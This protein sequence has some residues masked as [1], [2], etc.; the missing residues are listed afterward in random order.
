MVRPA[1][2]ERHRRPTSCASGRRAPTMMSA[3][4]L[5]V[6]EMRRAKVR[7]GLLVFAVGLLV[8]LILTQQAL[9]DGLLTSFVGGIRNQ[10]A[11]VLVYSVDGQKALQG[12][13]V[14][15]PLE[16]AVRRHRGRGRGGPARP[17]HLHR[18]GRGR[19]QL[20]RG[21]SSAPTSPG[22]ARRRPSRRGRGRAAD[23]EAV[24][25]DVDFS[26]GDEVT[27]PAAGPGAEPVTTDRGGPGPTTSSSRSP[28]TLFTDF[29]TY[30]AAVRAANPDATAV[31]PN[32][33]AVEPAD[34]RRRRPAG[35]AHRRRL[36]RGR[37]PHPRAGRR[38]VPRRGP[39]APVVPGDLP[40]LR[41]GR[42]PRHRPLLPHHH[43]PEVGVADPAAGRGGPGRR[44]G[45]VAAGPGRW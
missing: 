36:A 7:F 19:G 30:E 35:R 40:A 1:G 29:A 18:R 16:E 31:L 43:P 15:P 32:A 6:R 4:F 41:D 14:P 25:S 9:Q 13:I 22:W 2:C 42:A 11:P 21:R 3:V 20:R 34:G 28:P 44:A 24:G 5:A 33:I 45:P 39:G 10:S 37:R 12:S 26:L 27:V 8:F 17:E 38:R 23:G